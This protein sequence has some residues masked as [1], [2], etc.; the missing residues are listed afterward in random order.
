MS[1]KRLS[2]LAPFIARR[3]GGGYLHEAIRHRASN[4]PIHCQQHRD[5]RRI[6]NRSTDTGLT[7]TQQFNKWRDVKKVAGSISIAIRFVL[8]R[9]TGKNPNEWRD[10]EKVG[11]TVEVG[12]S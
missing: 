2:L 9:S 12:V 1:F 4:I 7:I 10:V 6:G 8:K 5:Y 3:W 11:A